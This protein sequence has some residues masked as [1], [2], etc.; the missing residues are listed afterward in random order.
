MKNLFLIISFV[1]AVTFQLAANNIITST[2]LD[3]LPNQKT[4]VLNLV[5]MDA[6]INTFSIYDAAGQLVYSQEVN[7][8]KNGVKYNLNK[9]PQGDYTIRV[10]ATNFV[11]IHEAIITKDSII[12]ENVSF[13]NRPSL[14][15]MGKKFVV[16]A[17]LANNEDVQ[18]YIYDAAGRMIYDYKEEGNGSFQ[19]TFNLENLTKGS[20]NVSVLTDAFNITRNISL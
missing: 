10:E 15:E 20:Y 16:N 5:G 4:I 12:L 14:V 18:V 2:S 19:K 17:E 8:T 9:L 11:E 6:D 3:V 13:H 1:S 7:N